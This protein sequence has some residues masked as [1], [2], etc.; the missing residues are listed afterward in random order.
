M[1]G[2]GSRHSDGL[3]GLWIDEQGLL[4]WMGCV[5]LVQED[6][7]PVYSK[8]LT[9]CRPLSTTSSVEQS[10][11]SPNGPSARWAPREVCGLNRSTI[12]L[13][14]EWDPGGERDAAG[15]D[16]VDFLVWK[17]A[18]QGRMWQESK[19]PRTGLAITL[20]RALQ[21]TSKWTI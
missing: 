9:K 15:P 18:G 21:E 8:R 17:E 20:P 11:V 4:V 12:H 6:R 2:G 1:G 14:V 10:P 13:W 19:K 16:K 7:G 5:L 3:Q